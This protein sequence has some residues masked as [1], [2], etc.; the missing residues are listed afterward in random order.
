MQT[1]KNISKPLLFLSVIILCSS[2]ASSVHPFYVGVQEL[3]LSSKDQSAKLSCRLFIDDLQQELVQ[4]TKEK[5]N[6]QKVNKHNTELLSNYILANYKVKVGNKEIPFKVLGYEVV[7]ESIW[8]YFEGRFEP[9]EKNVTI[10]NSLLC[11]SITQQN[12]LVHCSYDGIK[13]SSKMSC[14]E[15]VLSFEF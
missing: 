3:D 12:N 8:C 2:F 4:T 14:G 13:K 7:E 10:E 1:I 5:V 11:G 6:L 9:K 15:G